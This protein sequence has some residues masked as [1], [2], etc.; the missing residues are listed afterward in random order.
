[1]AHRFLRFKDGK[2]KAL[3]LS[4]DDVNAA[5]IQF[6]K[7]IS[8]YGI[9]CTFN[10]N[11]AA[12]ETN[13]T[14]TAECLKGFLD[15]GHEIAVHGHNHRSNGLVSPTEFIRDTLICRE[16]LEKTF[17]RIICGMAYPDSG[18][19]KFMNGNDYQTVKN[20]LTSLG[21]VYSR[22]LAGDNDGFEIP[23]DFH[24]WMPTAHHAN[25]NIFE[26]ID[27]FLDFD[28]NGVY[29]H[30]N[31]NASLF[32]MWGHA[33]EFERN[34]YGWE[35]L[36]KICEK[37]SGRQEIWY[38]TNMEIYEYV[39]AYKSLVFNT[40]ET[41]VYNPSATPVWFAFSTSKETKTYCVKPGETINIQ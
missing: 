21:I 18:I 13:E 31:H 25:K 23:T 30:T 27:K 10:I 32:Y 6:E 17:D 11:T 26:Y 5:N 40:G 16:I 1:M 15:R 35:H 9:K 29:Y 22:T 36:E 8:D 3:T 39:K 34:D 37:L 28:P 33:F 7:I 19:R 4:Y 41:K 12:L 38:A 14:C 24:A 20:S 2:T